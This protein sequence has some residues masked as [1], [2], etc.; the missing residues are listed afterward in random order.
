MAR[1]Y[2]GA[3]FNFTGTNVNP[4]A[5]KINITGESRSKTTAQTRAAGAIPGILYGHGIENQSVQVDAKE[6]TKIFSQ[7]GYTTLISLA[8]GKTA[9]NVLV[10]EVQ[11][12]PLKDLITH[13]DFYQVRLD[14]KVRAEVPLSFTGEAPAVKDLGGVL[15]KSIDAV[16]LEAFPQDLPHTIPVDI[17]SL[18]DFESII[19]VSDLDVP[20]GITLFTEPETV[21]AVVQA[22]R[23]EAELESLAEEVTEDVAAVETVEKKA[24]AEEE[25]AEGAGEESAEPEKK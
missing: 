21:V 4:M 19:H 20:S 10:R 7:T 23:S 1:A 2:E 24:E 22:P 3:G 5:E 15:V 9:H 8:I 12:H 14:E 18:K 17:S 16:D 11:F 6:F 25:P 13:V